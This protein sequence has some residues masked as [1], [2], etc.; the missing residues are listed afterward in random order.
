MDEEERGKAMITRRQ[1]MKMACAALGVSLVPASVRAILNEPYDAN[2]YPRFDPRHQYGDY[3]YLSGHH[4][5]DSD[6]ARKAITVL[7]EQIREYVPPVCRDK[8]V[9]S[10]REV[11][12]GEVMD[13]PATLVIWKYNP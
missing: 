10:S 3:V 6:E 1:F 12:V 4:S 13:I 11:M 7:Q 9:L 5:F 2:A 8:I